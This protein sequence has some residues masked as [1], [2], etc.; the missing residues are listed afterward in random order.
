MQLHSVYAQCP[1][2]SNQDLPLRVGPKGFF[3]AAGC[4]LGLGGAV[5][6]A[7][8]CSDVRPSSSQKRLHWWRALNWSMND[9]EQFPLKPL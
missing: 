8:G 6:L 2:P 1:V 9:V 7:L 3:L 4:A 5:R